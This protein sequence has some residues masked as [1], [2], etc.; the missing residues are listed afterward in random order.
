MAETVPISF[1]N[2]VVIVD[3]RRPT[4]ELPLIFLSPRF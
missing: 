3:A 1:R 2:C 4:P